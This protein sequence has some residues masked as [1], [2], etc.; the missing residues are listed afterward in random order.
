MLDAKYT[1][2]DEIIKKKVLLNHYLEMVSN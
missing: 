1:V 2:F